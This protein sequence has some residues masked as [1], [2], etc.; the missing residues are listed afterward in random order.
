MGRAGRQPAPHCGI[1]PDELDHRRVLAAFSLGQRHDDLGHGPLVGRRQAQRKPRGHRPDQRGEPLVHHVQPLQEADD[2]LVDPHP[3]G[4]ERLG[5]GLV[6]FDQPPVPQRP[7]R[8]HH[9]PGGPG[10]RGERE[11]QRRVRRHWIAACL[12]AAAGDAGVQLRRRGEQQDETL[13]PGQAEPVAQQLEGRRR[14]RLRPGLPPRR[15]IAVIAVGAEPLPRPGQPGRQVGAVYR[16]PVHVAGD[17][18]LPRLHDRT[19]C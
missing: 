10:K 11:R 4:G 13:E 2:A 5:A 18:G 7:L 1:G 12:G 17:V 3:G 8:G 15:D 16:L 19:S 9:V 6:E 14:L